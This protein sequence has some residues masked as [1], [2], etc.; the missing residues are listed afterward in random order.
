MKHLPLYLHGKSITQLLITEKTTTTTT[1]T[2]VLMLLSQLA[3]VSNVSSTSLSPFFWSYVS[4]SQARSFQVRLY[5][6]FARLPLLT[7]LS[8]SSYFNFHN[9]PYLGLDVSMHDETKT[10]QMAL[11]YHVSN[12]RNN[13]HPIMKNIS[14][15]PINQSHPTHHPCNLTSFVT[16]SSH[17]SQQ[18]NEIGPT[19][20]W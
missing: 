19:Q 6:L 10:L 9:S 12:L 14:Q 4:S 5:P 18:N 13:T 1:I 15:H 16:G 11:H 3:E 2:P 8:F 17:V 7:L 20:Q